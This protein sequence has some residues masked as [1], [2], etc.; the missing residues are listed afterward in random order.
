MREGVDAASLPDGT[1]EKELASHLYTA[2]QP[3]PDLLIRTSGELR[4]SGFM[5]WQAVHSELYFSPV[6]WPEFSQSDLATALGV[7]G[8]R[9]RRLGA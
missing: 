1:V 5:I 2:G 9:Q 7:F 6:P 8:G 3:D 4:L